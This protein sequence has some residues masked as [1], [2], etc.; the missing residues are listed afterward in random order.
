MKFTALK[1]ELLTKLSK[2]SSVASTNTTNPVTANVLLSVDNEHADR[3]LITCTDCEVQLSTFVYGV[4]VIEDGRITVNA[5]TLLELLKK[6]PTSASELKFTLSESSEKMTVSCGKFRSSMVTISAELFPEVVSV[7]QTFEYR[8]NSLE[9]LSLIKST[10][11]CVASDS[12]RLFLKGLR[13]ETEGDKLTVIGADGHRLAINSCTIPSVDYPATVS[14]RGFIMPKKATE[15]IYTLLN[16]AKKTLETNDEVV[17]SVSSNTISTHVS[18]VDL[19]SVKIDVAYPNVATIMFTD[20]TDRYTVDRKLLAETVSRVSVMSNNLNKAV[21]L[22]FNNDICEV[23]AANSKHED[24]VDAIETGVYSGRKGFSIALNAEYL[25][26]VCNIIET[27]KITLMFKNTLN[28]CMIVPTVTSDDE[29]HI[30]H[31]K[32]LISRIVL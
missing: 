9:L 27:D 24:C 12:Y 32:Y 10:K 2:I 25:L 22:C 19:L 4:N 5:K 3:L 23:K 31:Q 14:D 6:A 30:E 8:V 1:E 18:D 28:N 11:F 17:I 13:F 26:N 29:Q 16:N 15:Q 20:P 21:E 7:N